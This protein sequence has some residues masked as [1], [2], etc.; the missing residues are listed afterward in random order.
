MGLHAS[1]DHYEEEDF[2]RFSRKLGECTRALRLLLERPD[3]G[4][5]ALSIGAELELNLV[6]DAGRPALMNRLVLGDTLD[7]R[8]TLEVD[9]FNMEINARPVPLA[10]APFTATACELRDAVAAVRE[11]ARAHGAHVV[12]V[13]ILPTLQPDDL[14]PAALTESD[15]YRA[16][17]SGMRRLR[18]GAPLHFPLH[19]QGGEE[20]ELMAEDVA[21]E[22]ANTSFQ[23]H[24]RADPANFAA[25]YNAAQLA[26]GVA[27]AACGNSPIFL[28]KHLWDE[29]RI[30][31]FR[32]SV[33]ERTSVEPDDWRP[34]RVSFGHG[35]VR[36]GA[37]ELFE[38]AVHLHE[39]VLPACSEEDPLDAARAGRV[40]A[41][42]ELRLHNGTIWRWNRA[43]YDDALGGHLRVEMRALPAG[44]TLVDMAANAAFIVGLT[45]GLRPTM[46]DVVT[47]ITFGQVRRNFYA[48]A[49][50][51]LDAQLLWPETSGLTPRPAAA[52]ELGLRLL[53]LAREG[54]VREG[55]DPAEADAHLGVVR[56][57][58]EAGATGARWQRRLFSEISAEISDRALA[59]Q[60]MLARYRE[61][62]D[63]GAPV[64]T[65]PAR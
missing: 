37:L 52:R 49:A 45:L 10:G 19:I 59:A 53:P 65:W 54:L 31:L 2:A 58:L 9:R 20:L 7:R 38:E 39:P 63:M 14:T 5:G 41:L 43:V 64:H 12:T 1:R 36:R 17:S 60:R 35:W 47:R 33:D 32:Q 22:G 27:L 48:A 11:A 28:G 34:A 4:A 61:L 50:R 26:T 30:A 40:P 29:T 18:A 57:R 6:D 13:G 21:Y 56:D 51:G 55:V 46:E 3:F 24:L 8:V 44:P 42:A 15:R 16:I 23:I 25:T 62:S